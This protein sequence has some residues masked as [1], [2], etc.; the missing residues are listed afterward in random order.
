MKHEKEPVW[1]KSAEKCVESINKAGEKD[2]DARELEVE[3]KQQ[4]GKN[5]HC[6][7]SQ[8]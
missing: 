4:E 6:P 1:S 3:K 7:R 5:S 2:L 8:W